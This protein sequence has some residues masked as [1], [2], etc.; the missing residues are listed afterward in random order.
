MGALPIPK[1]SV[2]EYL[3]LDRMAEVP[4]EFHDG[5]M[6]PIEAVTYEH[7]VISVNVG[8]ALKMRLRSGRSGCQTIGS[9]LRVLV[10]PTKY[11]I[12]DHAV[13]CGE[14]AFT[15]KQRD[16]ITNPKVILEI[17]SPSTADYDYGHKFKLY[18]RLATFEEY[19]LISQDEALVER[20]RKS[21]E[22]RWILSIHMGL[23]AVVP[24]ESLSIS[25]PLVEIYE[26]VTFP[27]VVD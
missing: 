10:A 3:V 5:E 4:S 23:D 25:L 14:P 8:S 13:L 17:L 26:D 22:D 19:L 27:P 11:V 21:A 12:P 20:Y 6:F 7:S 2:E 15:D 18:R 9:P 1:L 16:T 24:I